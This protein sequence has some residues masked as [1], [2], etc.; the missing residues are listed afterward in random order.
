MRTMSR[1]GRG[2]CK[3]GRTCTHYQPVEVARASTRG[4]LRSVPS[5]R[6]D[7]HLATRAQS[8][9]FPTGRAAAG[10]R[11]A[12]CHMSKQAVTDVLH[13]AYTDHRIAAKPTHAEHATLP[14]KPVAFGS[15]A[16]PRDLALAEAGIAFARED[17]S[18][19][20]EAFVAL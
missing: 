4:C 11:C 10:D 13:A 18:L 17:S 6:T 20:R 9:R 7:P 15:A 3:I 19:A 12:S 1:A 8:G 2:S 16:P 14:G 5:H